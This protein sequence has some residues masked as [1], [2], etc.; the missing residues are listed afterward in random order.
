PR[1]ARYRLRVRQQSYERAAK[2]ASSLVPA[3]LRPCPLAP[4]LRLVVPA[5]VQASELPGFAP[6]CLEPP[7]RRGPV[8][9]PRP[10]LPAPRQLELRQAWFQPSPRWMLVSPRHHQLLLLPC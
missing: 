8:E 7:A 5:R 4:P 2:S 6:H 9:A 3:P 1:S 10:A